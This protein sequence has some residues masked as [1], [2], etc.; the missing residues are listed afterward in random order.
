MVY[1][2]NC[3]WN[4]TPKHVK[5]TAMC[6]S[7]SVKFHGSYLSIAEVLLLKGVCTLTGV[8]MALVLKSK[9]FYSILFEGSWGRGVFSSRHS[10]CCGVLHENVS[11]LMWLLGSLEWHS[12]FLTPGFTAISTGSVQGCPAKSDMFYC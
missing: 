8:S 6:I 11:D 3:V 5:M 2:I 12:T 9:C 10:I 4:K 7:I 1:N